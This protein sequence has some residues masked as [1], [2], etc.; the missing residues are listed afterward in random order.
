MRDNLTV[1]MTSV[2]V[3]Q[4]PMV[5]LYNNQRVTSPRL[6][7]Q[8]LFGIDKIKLCRNGGHNHLRFDGKKE[9]KIASIAW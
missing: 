2:A 9:E 3:N 6:A 4:V 5:G 7:L 1:C 8:G